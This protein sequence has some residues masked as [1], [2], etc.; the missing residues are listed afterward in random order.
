MIYIINALVMIATVPA[1]ITNDASPSDIL[2]VSDVKYGTSICITRMNY[3]L[4][5]KD[6]KQFIT[7]L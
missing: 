7:N 1:V 6:C 5:S 2:K 3:E 4:V